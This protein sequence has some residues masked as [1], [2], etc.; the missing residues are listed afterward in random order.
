VSNS[1]IV[2]GIIELLG[3]GQQ[4]AN[5]LCPG[6]TF[7]LAPGWDLSAPQP[8]TDYVETLV[9]DGSRPYGY[10]SDNRQPVLPV[11]I[12]A[13]TVALLAAARELLLQ[14]VNAQSWSL[15]WTRDGSTL[16]MILD[17][18]RA[19]ATT[20]TYSIPFQDAFV[21]MVSV[22]FPALPYG[23]SDTPQIVPFASPASVGTGTPSAPVSPV[24]IDA[25]ATVSGSG[26]TRSSQCVIGPWSLF[27]ASPG[28]G[29]PVYTKT[30]LSLNLTGQ[31]SIAAYIGLGSPSWPVWARWKKG[32]VSLAVT[33]LDSSGRSISIGTTQDH[34]ASNNQASP[35][36]KL[37]TGLIPASPVFNFAS[38]VGYTLTV[39]NFFGTPYGGT[40]LT[41]SLYV[42]TL[43]ALPVS[44]PSPAANLRGA[45][46]TI[47]PVG[48]ARAAVA[49][50]VQQ[51]VISAPTTVIL[52]GTGQFI[53][54]AGV[55]TLDV[56][57]LGGGGAGASLTASGVGAGGGGGESATEAT[58]SITGSAPI[59]YSCGA[60]GVPGSTGTT[61]VQF[62]SS[63]TATFTV[64]QGITSM[65]VECWAG[66]GGGGNGGAGGSG[67]EY[68]ASTA[69]AVTPGQVLTITVGRGGQGG[70]YGN[71]SSGRAS[72]ITGGTGTITANAGLGGI[73]GGSVGP[74][75]GS[76][77][78]APVHASGGAGG[79]SPAAGGGGGGE[80]G[81]GPPGSAS[82]GTA[83]SP[84]SSSSGAAGGS[85]GGNG[86]NGGNGGSSNNG[87]SNGAAPGGGGG[88][89]G[90]YSPD[91]GNSGGNGATG[92]V[93]ITFGSAAGTPAVSG[94][95][96][97]FGLATA[98]LC[99]ANG[100]VSA[101]TGSNT[102]GTGG[103]GSTDTAHFNGGTGTAGSS[104]SYGGAGASSAGT[105][106]AGVA[107]STSTG[108][109]PPAGG[110]KGGNGA[111]S[112]GNPGQPGV[113][114]GGGG[115]A[116]STG[117]G[118]LGGA[119][120]AGQIS[121]T[122]TATLAPF[123]TMLVHKPGPSAPPSL[124]PFVSTASS[125]DPPDGRQYA[126]PSLVAGQNARFNGT[127]SIML[128]VYSWDNPT[129]SRQITVTIYEYQYV[130]GPVASTPVVAQITPSAQSHNNIC[131]INNVTLPLHDIAGDNSTAYYTVGITSGDISD[132][133]L[134]VIFLDTS[135]Q[136]LFVATPVPYVNFYYDEP[137][138]TVAVGR[139]MGSAFDRSEALS[140]SDCVWGISG[141]PLTIDPATGNNKILCYCIEGAPALI[142]S[143]FPRWFT[144]RLV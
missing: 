61:V 96:T 13:P 19:N 62:T 121:V 136:T 141:G 24:V 6:A 12:Q 21:S 42:D 131:Y 112:S 70:S 37:F 10:R 35:A 11:V 66:G 56:T 5:P 84:S 7:R 132:R 138:S 91:F 45:L 46:Y 80:A 38:V 143:Y 20:V 140:V 55:L 8:A 92:M 25:Y 63:G 93:Q 89:G 104:G 59:P 105:A 58:L 48:T 120:G 123:A 128:G 65:I 15:T 14:T 115:G 117:A 9:L 47:Q 83:G 32:R 114:G 1:L 3:G 137:D 23:R 87:G 118:Q 134:D 85:S 73:S 95:A 29:A 41:P 94:Q 67:G 130:G 28:S 60:G 33:L 133:F 100:G 103:T 17:C 71:G 97:I 44:Q 27:W 30:G 72:S 79:A 49:L 50:N 31:S 57:S 127:Y 52:Q 34:T 4:S 68:A 102:P 75:G 22:P 90:V 129:A 135:G 81:S 74:A 108:G 126:M 125:S 43:I 40:L 116:W 111:V 82:A 106:A 98:P 110:G 78:S 51:P 122:Y 101:A 107:G 88:G 53:P 144:D 26:F 18:F 16:P 86:G 2:G 39:Y 99:Q 119:G 142:A 54:P 76:G 77:S 109:V 124:Q 139:I 113:T 36:W 69:Y 64:P